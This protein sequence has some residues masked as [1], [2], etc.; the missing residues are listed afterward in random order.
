MKSYNKL[1]IYSD[2]S[3]K[4]LRLYNSPYPELQE[5]DKIYRDSCILIS[6]TGLHLTGILENTNP[7]TI[8][9]S[10]TNKY[11][12]HTYYE[13]SLFFLQN[14]KSNPK[15]Y[16]KILNY[17]TNWRKLKKNRKPFNG[18]SARI[19]PSSIGGR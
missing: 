14:S 4:L 1:Q 13:P 9:N 11:F 5:K 18:E 8:N 3:T 10:F 17:I 6:G 15:E 19:L 16:Y 7:T 12:L 2:A